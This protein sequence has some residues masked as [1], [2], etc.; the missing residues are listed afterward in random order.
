MTSAPPRPD[1][2]STVGACT[3]VT[4]TRPFGAICVDRNSFLEN[5]VAALSTSMTQ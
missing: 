4:L 3:V 2:A 1:S 5:M